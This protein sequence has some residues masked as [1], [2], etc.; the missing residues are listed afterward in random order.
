MKALYKQGVLIVALTNCNSRKHPSAILQE[1]GH[2]LGNSIGLIC[3]HPNATIVTIVELTDTSEEKNAIDQFIRGR[4]RAVM[5]V[6]TLP[7]EFLIRLSDGAGTHNDNVL[8]SLED[9]V[10]KVNAGYQDL[11]L[12]CLN[13]N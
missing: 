11:E 4:T 2:K 13:D 7:A 8:N 10:A 3:T 12:A 1:I 6:S 5:K 9:L